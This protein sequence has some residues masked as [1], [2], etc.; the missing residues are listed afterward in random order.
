MKNKLLK[1]VTKNS[2]FDY[3]GVARRESPSTIK[4]FETYQKIKIF[5]GLIRTKLQRPE[6]KIILM[7]ISTNWRFGEK[8]RT[9][10]M[11]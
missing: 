11:T 2:T 4:F 7:H 5:L 8:N 10:K 3:T 1:P 6:K 9:S